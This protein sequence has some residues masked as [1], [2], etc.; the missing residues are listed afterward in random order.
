M[1][2]SEHK[3]SI[4]YLDYK[5]LLDFRDKYNQLI[6]DIRSCFDTSLHD[7]DKQEPIHFRA[8]VAIKN[9]GRK[10]LANKYKDSVIL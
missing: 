6:S 9:L 8:D 10:Y 7:I 2:Q 4:P 1:R 3:V 5:E